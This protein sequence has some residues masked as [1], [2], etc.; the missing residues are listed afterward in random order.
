MRRI[1]SPRVPERNRNDFCGEQQAF[2]RAIRRKFPGAL[3]V[4]S[5]TLVLA[6]ETSPRR[7]RAQPSED[8][9]PPVSTSSRDALVFDHPVSRIPPHST[10]WQVLSQLENDDAFDARYP[11]FWSASWFEHLLPETALLSVIAATLQRP[12]SHSELFEP[13]FCG[14][15]GCRERLLERK[16]SNPYIQI[17]RLQFPSVTAR[18]RNEA[19][20]QCRRQLD[21]IFGTLREHVKDGNGVLVAINAPSGFPSTSDSLPLDSRLFPVYA[22]SSSSLALR[23]VNDWVPFGYEL[24]KQHLCEALLNK[25]GDPW[26]EESTMAQW[27]IGVWVVSALALPQ[28]TKVLPVLSRTSPQETALGRIATAGRLC[29]AIERPCYF[30]DFEL[31]NRPFQHEAVLTVFDYSGMAKGQIGLRADSATS[32]AAAQRIQQYENEIGVKNTFGGRFYVSNGPM[33]DFWGHTYQRLYEQEREA[34]ASLASLLAMEGAAALGSSREAVLLL[35]QALEYS[36][37]PMSESKVGVRSPLRVLAL[38]RGDCDSLSLLAATL[39]AE[40]GED[41]GLVTGEVR[42]PDGSGGGHAMLAIR[43]G[44]VAPGESYFQSDVG[45]FLAVEMTSRR[46]PGESGAM[47]PPRGA[48]LADYGWELHPIR[49]SR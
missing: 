24:P 45:T 30:G 16:W 11:R 20:T 19:L 14:A 31:G 28:T 48:N 41:V 12:M 38:G 5:L 34:L 47:R 6:C 7:H 9:F 25:S 27:E 17:E 8:E 37:I 35:V 42:M 18:L 23:D 4:T 49:R 43:V 36:L 44:T 32:L 1:L 29:E 3:I 39:L 10:V 22:A 13:Q 33:D 46:P 21:E 2:R 26:Y 40:L 15:K